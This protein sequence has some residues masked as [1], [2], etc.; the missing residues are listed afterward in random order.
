[1]RG[2]RP[3]ASGQ[4]RI[5]GPAFT[6]RFVPARE[7]ISTP[8]SIVGPRSPRAAIE[9]MPEG[10]VVVADAMGI[11]DAGIFGDIVCARM[12]VRKVG[13]LVTDGAIRD[14]A[15]LVKLD[16]SVWANGTAA[17]ASPAEFYCAD[18]QV[19]V[20]C[21]GVAVLPGDIIVADDDGAI[22]IPAAMAESVAL[23]GR[24]KDRFEEWAFARVRAGELLAGLY[25]PD[26]KTKE[27]F[28]AEARD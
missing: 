6:I 4:P 22:V 9:K 27:R 26:E 20:A 21:G 24:D 18:T 13:G 19:A 14:L 17:P 23:A 12:Q 15:G 8:E 2:P 5:A 3:I 10:C 11:T 16:W 28:R 7:D 1:M 25:P